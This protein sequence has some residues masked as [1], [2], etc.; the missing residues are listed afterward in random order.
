MSNMGMLFTI[1]QR[2]YQGDDE[3]SVP[4]ALIVGGWLNVQVEIDL[5]TK[6]RR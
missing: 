3:S 5:G 6:L 2:L 1:R 4:G